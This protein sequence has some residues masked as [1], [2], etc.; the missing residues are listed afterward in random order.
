MPEIDDVVVWD[1][2]DVCERLKLA[3]C[4]G[5]AVRVRPPDTVCDGDSLAVPV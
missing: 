2:V 1:P 3:V 5:V 4:V